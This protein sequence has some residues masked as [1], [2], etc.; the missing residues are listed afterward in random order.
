LSLLY[1]IFSTLL[2]LPPL[3]FHCVE[4]RTVATSALT[5]RRSNHSA[6]VDLIHTRLDL[7]HTRLDLIQTQLDLIHSQLD[8]IHTR[9]DLILSRLD[10]IPARIHSPDSLSLQRNYRSVLLAISFVL[11]FCGPICQ[12][13]EC[14]ANYRPHLFLLTLARRPRKV[15][16]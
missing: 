11:L 16:L 10:L 15:F 14:Q 12:D 4:P 6:T 1:V 9:L 7:I 3:R 5:V 2:H 8:L 13:W